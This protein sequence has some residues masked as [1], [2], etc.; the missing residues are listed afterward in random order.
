MGN[1]RKK[2][3][4]AL[5]TLEKW[6][7]SALKVIFQTTFNI[8]LFKFRTRRSCSTII[9]RRISFRSSKLLENRINDCSTSMSLVVFLC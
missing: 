1:D 4:I 8:K 7:P 3:N 2:T 5:A 9:G 6:I